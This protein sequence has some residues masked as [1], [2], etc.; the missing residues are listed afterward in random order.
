[1]AS[2]SYLRVKNMEYLKQRCGTTGTVDIFK[3]VGQQKTLTALEEE[4]T[5]GSI[6]LGFTL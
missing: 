4:N 3:L 5:I 2:W 6:S 1:M